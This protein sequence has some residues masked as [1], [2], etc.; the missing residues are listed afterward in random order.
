V[1]EVA[2]S[3]VTAPASAGSSFEIDTRRLARRPPFYEPIFNTFDVILQARG[4][5]R[6]DDWTVN[7]DEQA[8]VGLMVVDQKMRTRSTRTGPSTAVTEEVC[9]H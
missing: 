1:S 4:H 9:R 3:F 7:L 2:N 6:D 8:L 5:E